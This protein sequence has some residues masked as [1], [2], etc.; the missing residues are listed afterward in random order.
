[1]GGGPAGTWRPSSICHLDAAW[2]PQRRAA[3]GL[4]EQAGARTERQQRP[5]PAA[6][7]HKAPHTRLEKQLF[8]GSFRPSPVQA[9]FYLGEK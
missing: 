4:K 2:G 7:P 3:L 8:S 9:I 5:L 6:V 1:M